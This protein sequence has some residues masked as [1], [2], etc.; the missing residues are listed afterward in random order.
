MEAMLNLLCSETLLKL[1]LNIITPE[2]VKIMKV[3]CPNI[4]FLHVNVL[5]KKFLDSTIPIICELSSLKFLHIE[6]DSSVD[7]G[8]LVKILGDY[9]IFVEYLSFNFYIDLPSFEYFTNN[10]KANLRKW[11]IVLF[12]D[13]FRKDY[14]K[15]V[16]DY[17]KV[18]NSL[19]ELGIDDY[20]FGGFHWTIGELEIIDSLKNQNVNTVYSPFSKII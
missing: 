13:H 1:S 14:L 15:H 11:N 17:Q 16:N 7:A 4:Q 9:L 19:K 8:L 2:S 12:I 5:T 10:C 3:H 20:C 6:I 18:H